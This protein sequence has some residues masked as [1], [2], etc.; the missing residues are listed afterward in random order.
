MKKTGYCI[1]VILYIVNIIVSAIFDLNTKNTWWA[2]AGTLTIITPSF[3]Q[4]VFNIK[5]N[6]DHDNIAVMYVILVLLILMYIAGI[7]IFTAGIS[8]FLKLPLY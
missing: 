2:L 1:S 7:I 3:I 6:K 8:G 4:T 5:S